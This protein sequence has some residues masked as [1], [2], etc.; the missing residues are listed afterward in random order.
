M[1]FFWCSA[2]SEGAIGA[3][4]EREEDS[5]RE[6]RYLSTSSGVSV[7]SGPTVTTGVMHLLT[8]IQ[9]PEGG[10]WVTVVDLALL[11]SHRKAGLRE[12]E[13]L[14]EFL[15]SKDKHV[16]GLQLLSDRCF[17]VPRDG[18]VAQMFQLRLGPAVGKMS[19]DAD[20]EKKSK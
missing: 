6:R 13:K 19:A 4:G 11:W 16:A 12:P 10:C 9:I 15:V 7:L 14:A 20:G 17:V 18:E 1:R 3:A 5:R 2:P 8:A